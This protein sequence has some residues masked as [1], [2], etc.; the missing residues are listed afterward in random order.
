[1]NQPRM[2]WAGSD[3]GWMIDVE[4]SLTPMEFQR[5]VDYTLKVQAERYLGTITGPKRDECLETMKALREGRVTQNFVGRGDHVIH[6]AY[7]SQGKR[8]FS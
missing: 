7:K 5:C 4:N 1:M 6:D 3:K 8:V 2:W